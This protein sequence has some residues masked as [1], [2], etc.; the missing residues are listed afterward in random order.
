MPIHYFQYFLVHRLG[1]QGHRRVREEQP[2]PLGLQEQRGPWAHLV[3][4]A[5]L[6]IREYKVCV[7]RKDRR[8]RREYKVHQVLQDLRVLPELREPLDLRVL[9]ERKA[10]KVLRELLVKQVN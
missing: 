4:R 9:P 7:D 2:G 1:L 6:Q 3:S 5:Y 10:R 8:V